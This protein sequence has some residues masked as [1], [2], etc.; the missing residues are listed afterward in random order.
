MLTLQLIYEAVHI[1]S[2]CGV[3]TAVCSHTRAA[4]KV[5]FTART[6]LC[7]RIPAATKQKTSEP[8]FLFIYL[9]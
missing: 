6:R 2:L 4:Q 3:A 9:F 1:V 7:D 5:A 8:A